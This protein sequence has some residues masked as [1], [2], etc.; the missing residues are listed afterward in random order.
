VSPP[1]PPKALL[2]DLDGT[3]AETDSLHFP[4]WADLLGRHGVHVDWDFYQRRISGRLNPDILADLAPHVPEHEAERLLQHKED[5][6][7]R[8]ATELQPL[9]GLMRVLKES[10]RLGLATALVTNA[11][12]E[13][14][15]AMTGALGLGGFFD[16]EV[17][18]GDLPAGKPDPL[19][20][21]TALERLG[22]AASDALAF[23]D[24]SSGIASAVGAGITTVGIASTHE[25]ET[26]LAAGAS[27]AYPDF[28]SPELLDLIFGDSR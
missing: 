8:R 15:H 16:A 22:V 28:D 19:A 10:R 17:L 18:A 13:N 26:L 25:P 1:K 27:H 21:S 11:P 12:E 3:L 4:L 9:P 24:S 23:E 5:E 14:A 2:F 20:Y 6:F 7:R